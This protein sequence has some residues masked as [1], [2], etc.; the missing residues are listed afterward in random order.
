MVEDGVVSLTDREGKPALDDSGYRYS[1]KLAEG[2]NA[3]TIAGR[4]TRELRLALRGRD[5]PVQGFDRASA[6]MA[7]QKLEYV[8][9]DERPIGFILSCTSGWKSYDVDG[10]PLGIFP[11]END[12]ARAVYHHAGAGCAA[13]SGG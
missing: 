1:K 6:A 5:A 4:L 3:K 9:S 7:D 11:N 8:I 10:Q 2:E 13:N 12:A